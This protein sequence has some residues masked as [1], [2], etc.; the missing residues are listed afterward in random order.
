MPRETF[1]KILSSSLNNTA[2]KVNPALT[3]EDWS[4]I[5][6]LGKIHRVLPIM[7]DKISEVYPFDKSDLESLKRRTKLLVAQQTYQTYLF[8]NLSNELKKLGL[9]PIVVKGIICRSIYPDPDYRISTDEDLLVPQK[10]FNQYLSAFEALSFSA[11]KE[12]N[13]NSYQNTFRSSD[14]LSVE[15]HTSLFP[16]NSEFFTCWNRTFENCFE[17]AIEIN[18]GDCHL[19]TLAPTDNLL[20]LLLHAVKHFLH[21]GV[22]IRQICDVLMFAT[23]FG[24]EI[25]W[26]DFSQYVKNSLSKTLL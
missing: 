6:V 20:Y 4:T 3:K 15:L 13:S 14:G 10:D 24:K 11:Q 12:I 1:L 21:G 9:S 8:R 16:T 5:F 17:N 25:N 2:L 18:T 22:G 23:A 19:V 7:Y 26:E